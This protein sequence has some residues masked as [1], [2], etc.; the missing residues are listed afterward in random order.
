MHATVH[1]LSSQRKHCRASA[2][3]VCV[4]SLRVFCSVFRQV[5]RD[6]VSLGLLSDGH[7]EIDEPASTHLTV[8]DSNRQ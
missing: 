5:E 8:T 7:W 6:P 3:C 2:H 4:R 1:A